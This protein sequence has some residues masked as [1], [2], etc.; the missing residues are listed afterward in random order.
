MLNAEQFR[1]LAEGALV[2]V[3]VTALAV[4]WGTVA[5]ILLGIGSL[6]PVAPLRWLVR[7]YVEVV[8]GVSAIILLVWLYFALPLFGP[9][10]SSLQAGVLALG[11][12]LSAYGAELVR[13]ALQ[14]LPKGQTE[15]GIA[16]NLSGRQRM[17]SIVLPQAM[18]TM[19]PPYGNLVIEVMKASS[20]VY[21][22]SLRDITQRAQN[23][24]QLREADTI[25]IFAAALVLYFVIS[26]AITGITRL[27]E[28]HYG[29]GL[30]TGRMAKAVK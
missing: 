25:D 11:L 7:V 13:G 15:A 9:E 1:V 14:A 29:R 6:S 5:A 30:D 18:V 2:T 17:W 10:L 26:L 23:M 8:R 20:L 22:V 21:L 24:R 4:A 27:L 19:L 16:I 12:N 3:Q 28:R